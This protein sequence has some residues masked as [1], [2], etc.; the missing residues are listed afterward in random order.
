MILSLVIFCPVKKREA[1]AFSPKWD[2][3]DRA[4]E[5]CGS[6]DDISSEVECVACK[7]NHKIELRKY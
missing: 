6:C 2:T 7:Q 4:Y 1:R 3:K 5:V